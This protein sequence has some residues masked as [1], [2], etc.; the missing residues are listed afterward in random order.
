MLLALSPRDLAKH[1]HRG[2][3]HEEMPKMINSNISGGDRFRHRRSADLHTVTGYCNHPTLIKRSRSC[4]AS[5]YTATKISA[6]L[7]LIG[8]TEIRDRILV[9]QTFCWGVRLF[10]RSGLWWRLAPP[11]L[12]YSPVCEVWRL[13]SRCQRAWIREDVLIETM[14]LVKAFIGLRKPSVGVAPRYG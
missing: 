4:S 12:E 5:Q 14:V 3:R 13:D 2:Q 11:F 6:I 7:N 1:L 10:T 8:S 9:V